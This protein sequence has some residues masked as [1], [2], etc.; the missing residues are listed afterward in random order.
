MGWACEVESR[1]SHSNK[2][3]SWRRTAE[4]FGRIK[5]DLL[6]RMKQHSSVPSRKE[7]YPHPVTI[8]PYIYLSG[9]V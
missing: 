2:A 6:M 1:C 7:I 5:R 4:N 9:T 3:N 8:R